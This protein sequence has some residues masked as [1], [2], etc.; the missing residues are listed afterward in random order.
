MIA[1]RSGP[2][3]ITN[4]RLTGWR[5]ELGQLLEDDDERW[6]AFGFSKPSDPDTPEVPENLVIVP[7]P[8]G[9]HMVFIDGT[10]PCE[11][12]ATGT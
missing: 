8:A 7:G 2:A 6:Y 9:S 3:G 11:R 5:N 10:T 1:S 12:L 4:R